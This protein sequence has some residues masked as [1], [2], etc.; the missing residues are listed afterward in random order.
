[1]I[2]LWPR[3]WSDGSSQGTRYRPVVTACLTAFTVL[4]AVAEAD[5]LA[6]AVAVEKKRTGVAEAIGVGVIVGVTETD[7][8]IKVV[9]V[10]SLRSSR[11]STPRP[12]GSTMYGPGV[13]P[14]N[15]T[16]S[17][18]SSGFWPVRATFNS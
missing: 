18:P 7:R 10:F 11:K 14:A 15:S 3:G 5:G 12:S 13:R 17:A 16:L 2:L 1:M 6:I 9:S 8:N 4:L